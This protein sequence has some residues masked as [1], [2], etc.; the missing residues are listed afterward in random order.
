M[1]Q[2][3]ISELWVSIYLSIPPGRPA[4][5]LPPTFVQLTPRRPVWIVNEV[6]GWRRP[7]TSQDARWQ[8][9]S[10][11][12]GIARRGG[13]KVTS[14]GGGGGGVASGGGSGSFGS[15]GGGGVV[16]SRCSVGGVTSGGGNGVLR[17]E[18]V[19]VETTKVFSSS[20]RIASH[21]A[22]PC[23]KAAAAA[24]APSMTGTTIV[25]P[26]SDLWAGHGHP[27]L[28]SLLVFPD[29]PAPTCILPESAHV[30]RGEEGHATRV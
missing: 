11:R 12:G 2:S 16:A 10:V 22:S 27:L 6:G 7:R 21:L 5:P 24:D 23:W 19:V 18:V 17:S 13:G 20:P 1:A 4:L 15:G 14:R 26:S 30:P 25:V 28:G 29:A 9:T 3:A 8:P